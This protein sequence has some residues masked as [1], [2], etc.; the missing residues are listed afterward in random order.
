[1]GD[2]K[3]KAECEKE[4]VRKF[5]TYKKFHIFP[6]KTEELQEHLT[7]ARVLWLEKHLSKTRT[8]GAPRQQCAKCNGEGTRIQDGKQVKCPKMADGNFLGWWPD[9]NDT[10]YNIDYDPTVEELQDLVK[11]LNCDSCADVKMPENNEQDNEQVEAEKAEEFRKAF[12]KKILEH[13]GDDHRHVMNEAGRPRGDSN[14]SNR[15]SNTQGSVT[16]TASDGSL[17]ESRTEIVKD[18]KVTRQPLGELDNVMDMRTPEHVAAGAYMKADG[19]MPSGELSPSKELLSRRR[20][21]HGIRTPPV[22]ATL[23]EEIEEAERKYR[24]RR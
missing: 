7:S 14:A 24:L 9:T 20:L 23:M 12:I 11:E 15:T 8:R 21:T 6:I 5:K 19:T 1:M 17:T 10:K 22:L 4:R 13:H 18:P 16:T 3:E 2:D